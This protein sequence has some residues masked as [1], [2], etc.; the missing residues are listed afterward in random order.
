[1]SIGIQYQAAYPDGT[2]QNV[3]VGAASVRSSAF[4][5]D[6][7][8]VELNIFGAGCHIE[9]GNSSVTATDQS[10]HYADGQTIYYAIDSNITHLAC[11]QDS[12]A[13]TGFVYIKEVE[14]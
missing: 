13:G 9:F 8:M 14:R 12:A 2:N 4:Q 7:K 10:H 6:T 3:A 1:M 11:I 5:S